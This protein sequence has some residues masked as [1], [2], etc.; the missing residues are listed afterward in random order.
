MQT[1]QHFQCPT[2]SADFSTRE[3]LDQHKLQAHQQTQ[4]TLG[5]QCDLCGAE[6]T[7]QEQLTDHKKQVH[8]HEL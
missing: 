6:F 3:Q 7:A 1:Q 2:C 8:Q 4:A 5:F